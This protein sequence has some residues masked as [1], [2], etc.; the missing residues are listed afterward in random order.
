MRDTGLFPFDD[1]DPSQAQRL[2]RDEKRAWRTAAHGYRGSSAGGGLSTSADMLRFARGLVGHRIVS[3]RMLD[4][5]TT[6]KTSGLPGSPM[7]YG[8]GFILTQR[9]VR[10]FGHGGIAS[11]VNFEFRYFPESDITV[12]AFS[13][14]DNG[15]YDD[16]RRNTIKLITGER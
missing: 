9:P 2:A 5:M 4:D 14:Q 3:A 7:A 16:L 1:R 8:Y 6:S 15:A 12:I 11:G 13:N 10:S